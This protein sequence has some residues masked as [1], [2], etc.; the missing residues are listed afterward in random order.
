MEHSPAPVREYRMKEVV[1]ETVEV[2]PQPP[3]SP[4]KEGKVGN[5]LKAADVVEIFCSKPQDKSERGRITKELCSRFPVSKYTI[6]DIWNGRSWLS[7][8]SAITKQKKGAT[9][10][11]A[12]DVNMEDAC[13]PELADDASVSNADTVGSPPKDADGMEDQLH[14]SRQYSSPRKNNTAATH[15]HGSEDDGFT[16]HQSPAADDEET[17]EMPN[18]VADPFQLAPCGYKIIPSGRK[19]DGE[20]QPYS[21]VNKT[22]DNKDSG[23]KAGTV[24]VQ[25]NAHYEFLAQKSAYVVYVC[26]GEGR[27]AFSLVEET[28]EGPSTPPLPCGEQ[29]VTENHMINLK[30][31][32]GVV[33]Y[34]TSETVDLCIVWFS[35][36]LA[37]PARH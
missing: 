14:S 2:V 10:S 21:L 12:A 24:V 33:F 6:R 31:G 30:R 23:T 3:L 20:Q 29:E 34:N 26:Q 22:F 11:V 27:A 17:A 16:T 35:N 15:A 8:T 36:K 9:G 13:T 5:V 1:Q 18:S 37:P 32:T 19:P 7:V 4:G 25:P 28:G